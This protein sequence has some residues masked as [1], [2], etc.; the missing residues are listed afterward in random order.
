MS[1]CL[2]RSLFGRHLLLIV[3]LI[4]CAEIGVALGFHLLIQMPRIERMAEMSQKYLGVLSEAMTHMSPAER[5]RFTAQLAQGDGPVLLSRSQP[6]NLTTPRAWLTRAAFARL[7]RRLGETYA[8]AW[9]EPPQ[10]RIWL[11]TTVAGE[12]WWLGLEA[13]SLTASRGLL[14]FG[15]MLVTALLAALGA[16]LIQRHIHRPLRQLEAAADGLADGRYPAIEMAGAPS[17]IARLAERFEHMAR[18]LEAVDRERG[19]MLAGISHDLRTPLAKLR[20]AVEILQVPGEEAL[21]QGMA[22]NIAA[23]DQIIDQFIDF[24]RLG[25]S[26]PATLCNAEELLR[27]VL[28]SFSSGRLKL[29][30]PDGELPPLACHPVAVRR[31]V[32]N[33]V[34]NALKYSAAE[35]E[36]G[37][38]RLGNTLHIRVADHGPGIPEAEMARLRQAF[39]RL[40]PA[41]G[42]PSGAGLGLAIVERIMNQEGGR[43]SLRNRPE[44]GLEAELSL[45]GLIDGTLA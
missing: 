20:L 30:A 28:G 23:A 19:I 8:L 16:G 45:P 18:R 2:P 5:Q 44:G 15:I 35:V 7:Q 13:G 25:E 39:T 27:D 42:G 29:L 40:A 37:L 3:G 22:R 14:V 10:A 6:A 11:R 38:S 32:A 26:E 43:L 9:T 41:R 1:R 4:L 34:G 31:A 12:T 24:A 17:E 36:I 21:L 33:L